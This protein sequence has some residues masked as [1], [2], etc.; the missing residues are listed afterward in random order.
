MLLL[1]AVIGF[2]RHN[3]KFAD[4]VNR[5]NPNQSVE[6]SQKLLAYFNTIKTDP[7][8]SKQLFEEIL[9][10][11]DVKKEVAVSLQTDQIITPPAVDEA[12]LHITTDKGEQAVTDYLTN[13]VGPVVAFNQKTTELNKSLFNGDINVPD[14]VRSEY[15]TL[16]FKL[17]SVSVPKE[18]VALHTALLSSFYAYGNLLKTA[19]AYDKQPTQEPW[20][21]VYQSYAAINTTAATY[22]KEFEKLNSKY[23]LASLAP[24]HYAEKET[25]QGVFL[26]PE[27]HAVF[28]LGDFTIT[29]GDIPSYIMD[30]VKEG[31][32]SSFTKFMALFLEKMLDKIE[33]NYLVAN[34]LYYSDALVSGQ[35]ADDYLNKY[36]QDQFDRKVIKQF[37]PQFA[38]GQQP[39]NLKPFFQAKANTYLGFD[40]SNIDT[41]D[42]QYYAKLTKVGDFLSEPTGWQ[43]HYQDLADQ[44]EAEAQQS[45]TRELTSSGLK[46]PRDTVQ[47]S[48]SS[49]INSIVSAQ[50]AGF[51]A[52][53]N[54]GISNASSFISAFVTSITENLVNKFVFRGVVANNN[55]SIAVLKE[56]STCLAAAQFQLVLPTSITDYQTPPPAP[57]PGSVI[58]SACATLP[59][60]CDTG[61]AK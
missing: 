41:S 7:A 19:I 20:P 33:Q 56:Q 2:S 23:K 30:A 18:A 52:I 46:T 4:T 45:A 11:E 60:G 29:V 28:G 42:P 31:L 37:I 24:L 14:G 27:A 43:T 1:A 22:A 32:I 50:Q 21:Q 55:G 10:K 9:T 47:N 49:S 40:P 17:E 48:I 57:D 15:N 13:T 59:R 5:V 39:A 8:A 54:L 58:N 38:C 6:D 36:I 61:V 26:V 25:V 34:F 44:A 51:N 35:Y 3:F 53:L 12:G 16:K